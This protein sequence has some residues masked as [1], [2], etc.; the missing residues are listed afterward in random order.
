MDWAYKA[1]L[2]ALAVA[3]VLMV[4]TLF[5]RRLSGLLAGLPVITAPA[6]LWLAHER[7]AEFA[8]LSAT[9]SVAASAAEALLAATYDRA[10]RRLGPW[11]TL[12]V[13]LAL[14][15]V[16]AMLMVNAASS[17]LLALTL[18]LPAFVL[19]LR[20]L[21]F[22]TVARSEGR[23]VHARILLVAAVAGLVSA[24]VALVSAAVGPYWSGLLA[25]MPVISTF[26]LLHQHV[27]LGG[28]TLRPFLSG[29]VSGLLGKALFAASF[30]WLVPHT[31]IELS[32]VLAG[33]AGVAC[34]LWL[35]LYADK[36][37]STAPAGTE[38]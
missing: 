32:F 31:S 1:M 4:A 18:A 24:G 9:G 22:E 33:S 17:T 2:T 26:A 29:Y 5:S 34:A 10:A 14:G 20:A 36:A 35:P 16:A 25:S 8:A 3:A 13:S 7:G 21:P 23:G 19:A 27:T 11:L 37:R 12:G 30:A 28:E 15:G 6:L 38:R